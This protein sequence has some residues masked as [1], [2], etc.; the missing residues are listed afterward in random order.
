ME[1]GG[2]TEFAKELFHFAQAMGLDEKLINSLRRF[3]FSRTSHLAFVHSMLV[4]PNHPENLRNVTLTINSGGSH[5]GREI[6]RTGYCGLGRAVRNLALHT[7][8][9][10]DIDVVVWNTHMLLE[11]CYRC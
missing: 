3:D 10:L 7:D 1:G 9:T 5:S 8:E 2:L 11:A 6:E 4:A